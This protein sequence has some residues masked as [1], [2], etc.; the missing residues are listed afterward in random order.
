M[1]LP[2]RRVAISLITSGAIWIS[3]GLELP[4]PTSLL[5]G[6]MQVADLGDAPLQYQVD[7]AHLVWGRGEVAIRGLSVRQSDTELLS[8][9]SAS[10]TFAI[11]IFSRPAIFLEKVDAIDFAVNLDLSK[12]PAPDPDANVPDFGALL[13]QLQALPAAKLNIQNASANLRWSLPEKAAIEAKVQLSIQGDTHTGVTVNLDAQTHDINLTSQTQLSATSN[14]WHLRSRGTSN[15]INPSG[16]AIDRLRQ[17][18][19]NA[20][21]IL[22]ALN[23]RGAPSAQ[24]SFDY[25]IPAAATNETA[26]DFKW[27]VAASFDDLGVTYQG[28]PTAAGTRAA[29]PYPADDLEG[30][31]TFSN[32]HLVFLADSSANKADIAAAGHLHFDPQGLDIDIQIQVD[33]APIDQEVFTALEGIPDVTPIVEQLGLAQQG[34]A[35]A[36][37][38]IA[39]TPGVKPVLYLDLIGRDISLQPSIPG[40]LLPPIPVS[41]GRL[42]LQ[43]NHIRFSGNAGLYGGQS[44]AHGF[45]HRRQGVASTPLVSLQISGTDLQPSYSQLGKLLP[46][47]KL[48]DITPDYTAKTRT[49]LSALLDGFVPQIQLHHQFHDGLASNLPNQLS[50]S[51]ITGDFFINGPVDALQLTLPLATA[52]SCKGQFATTLTPQQELLITT[53]GCILE[54]DLIGQWSSQLGVNALDIYQCS[55]RLDAQAFIP[56]TAPETLQANFKLRPFNIKTRED[57]LLANA[58]PAL[59]VQGDW[60]LHRLSPPHLTA[61]ELELHSLWGIATARD[62]NLE[63]LEDGSLAITTQW[64]SHTGIAIHPESVAFFGDGPANAIRDLGLSAW[65]RPRDLRI[66]LTL[67]KNAFPALSADGSL[68]LRNFALTAGPGIRQGQADLSIQKFQWAGNDTDIIQIQAT[69]GSASIS[70]I[71]VRDAIAG[72]TLTPKGASVVDFEASLLDGE[73]YTSYMESPGFIQVAFEPGTPVAAKLYADDL[74]LTSLQEQL[75]LPGALSGAVSGFVN[76]SGPTPNPLTLAGDGW[77]KIKNGSLGTV[78]VLSAVFRAA[79]IDPPVFQT[80][81]FVFS[82]NG[83]GGTRVHKLQLEHPLLEVTGKGWVAADT[84]LQL[85]ATIRTLSFLGRLPGIS[86]FLDWF[87]EQDISGPAERPIISLR[88]I[89]KLFAG[90]LPTGPFPLWLPTV[91][92]P[93]G[94]LSP[95]IPVNR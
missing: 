31:A 73:I 79:G 86:H 46:Q 76:L 91:T 75:N 33:D 48:P 66:N 25:A 7:E 53:R 65:V 70:G 92:E 61:G 14:A 63:A 42:S 27:A 36:Q 10:T 51:N 9:Q 43:P 57:L 21:P 4:L 28:L 74:Q 49:Q 12:L 88:G 30:I 15:G 6:E 72:I 45:V 37:L 17:L 84:T 69:K 81:E 58:L 55:A 59:T 94:L 38:R 67:K 95:A 56:L 23:L 2:S 40:L 13:A 54:P 68:E 20:I 64:E 1:N 93:D 47:L 60:K 90:D 62:F 82:T 71:P 83:R 41:S 89:R 32:R 44:T 8:L 52:L 11:P 39:G 22:D 77:A 85:K 5:Q 29:F 35:D 18:V 87:V 19:P 34:V 80:G 3:A 16:A 26:N 50:A 78:P 24:F